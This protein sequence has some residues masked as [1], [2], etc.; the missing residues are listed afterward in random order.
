MARCERIT[1]TPSCCRRAS[2][3]RQCEAVRELA[4]P[5][6]RVAARV[7]E[8]VLRILSGVQ[9]A[10]GRHLRQQPIEKRHPPLP[11]PLPGL[12]LLREKEKLNN[13][14]SGVVE[15]TRLPGA[16][17]V[18]DTKKEAIAVKE[19]RRLC[20]PPGIGAPVGRN[21]PAVQKKTKPLRAIPGKSNMVE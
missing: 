14:L 21:F 1:R 9:Q 12:F 19:A 16:L 5:R 10:L 18:V 7:N 4:V 15:M 13:V 2:P 11:P 3:L 8:P 17:Y 6:A 20:G